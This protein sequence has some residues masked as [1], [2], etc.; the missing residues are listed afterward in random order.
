MLAA[1]E[2]EIVVALATTGLEGDKLVT[3][4]VAELNVVFRDMAMFVPKLAA[5]PTL[6]MF[7]EPVPVGLD[8]DVAVYAMLDGPVSPTREKSPE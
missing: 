8:I 4:S 7:I 6:V 2:P 5:V 1:L 3:E